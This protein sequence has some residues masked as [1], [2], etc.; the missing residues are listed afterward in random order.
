MSFTV[1]SFFTIGTPY[2]QEI[3]GLRDSLEGLGVDHDIRGV[4][5]FGS[6]EANT[7]HKPFFIR[8]MLDEHRG[9]VVWL[10]ADAVVRKYP[11]LFTMVMADVGV[12][13]QLTG[14]TAK[15]FG[16]VE[17]VTATMFF[18]NNDRARS[19][20]DAWISEQDRPDQPEIQLIEQRALQRAIPAWRQA[21]GGSVS[22]L[23]QS[24]CKIFDSQDDKIITQHQ[25]SRRFGRS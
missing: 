18:S 24:Y 9:P 20:L 21:C 14:P 19:L 8:K 17:L 15:R 1:V 3:R 11:H 4:P 23:P 16:G 5:N 2:E 6:W 10:D 25:A 13:Y 7:R 22:F 12:Y